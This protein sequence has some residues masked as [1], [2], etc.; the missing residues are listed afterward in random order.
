M[1][2]NERIRKKAGEQI[3]GRVCRNETTEPEG[4]QGGRTTT[5]MPK[6]KGKHSGHHRKRGERM[7]KCKDKHGDDTAREKKMALAIPLSN[8]RGGRERQLSR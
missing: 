6:I 4:R 2:K 8:G 3:V 7:E 5:D 1:N